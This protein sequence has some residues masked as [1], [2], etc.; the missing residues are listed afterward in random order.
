MFPVKVGW[1]KWKC[2]VSFLWKSVEAF[3]RKAGWKF[4]SNNILYKYTLIE[5]SVKYL[6]LAMILAMIL[7]IWLAPAYTGSITLIY[8]FQS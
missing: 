4:E 6:K 3:S 8:I 7:A 1:H 5:Q 2:I